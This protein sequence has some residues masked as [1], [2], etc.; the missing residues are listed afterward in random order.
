M[1][2][3]DPVQAPDP[4]GDG[5]WISQHMRFVFQTSEREPDV[6]LLGDSILLNMQFTKVYQTYLEPLHCVNFSIYS[7]Q[8]QNILWR[9]ENGELGGFSP[10]VIVIMIGTHN[11]THS[12]EEV[13]RGITTIVETVKRKQPHASVIV[14]GLLPCGREPNP[15][16]AKHEKVNKL[17]SKEFDQ[18]SKVTFIHP[19]WENFIQPNGTISHRDMYD[20]MHPTESGYAK[21]ADPLIEELQNSLQTFLKTNAPSN[22]LVE[23]P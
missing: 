15:R 14:M 6:V 4:A 7:D 5:C 10:K 2:S 19:D 22:S 8:T 1:S 9:I 16:R 17:L 20:Y 21:L 18:Q 11:V 13:V 3:V 23:E 12:A